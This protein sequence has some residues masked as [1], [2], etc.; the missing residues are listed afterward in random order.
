MGLRGVIRGKLIRTTYSDKAAPCSA[1]HVNRQFHAPRPNV[2]WVSDFIL[3]SSPRTDFMS[4]PGRASSTWLSSPIPTPTGS[5]A[6]GPRERVRDVAD[7]L[8]QILP[9]QVAQSA[10]RCTGTPFPLLETVLIEG[11]TDRQPFAGVS[12]QESQQR[13]LRLAADRAL[14]VAREV[15]VRQPSLDDLAHAEYLRIIGV[16]GYAL[17]P[18][19]SRKVIMAEADQWLGGCGGV[20]QKCGYRG[21]WCIGRVVTVAGHPVGRGFPARAMRWRCVSL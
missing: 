4:A 9:C 17:A 2:L 10:G 13:N 16:A 6:E 20:V 8:A 11:H 5:S 7:V 3:G 21:P 14:S 12:A 18:K 1:D 15:L 19:C